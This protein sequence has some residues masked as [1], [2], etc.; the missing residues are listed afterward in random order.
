MKNILLLDTSFSAK[1]IY[2][3]LEKSGNVYVMGNRPDDFLAKISPNYINQNYADIE[4]VLKVLDNFKINFLVPGGNDFSYKI[5]SKINSIIPFYNTD[6]EEVN[7]IINNKEKF[8]KFSINNNLNVPKLVDEDNI[9]NHL[10]VIIKSVDAYSG[11]GMTIIDNENIDL[12]QESIENA[13]SF[14]KSGNYIIEEFVEG[15]LYSHSAFISNGKIIEDFIVKEYCSTNQYVVDISYVDDDFT[16]QMR[17]EIRKDITTIA[18]ELTL[19]DGLIHTQFIANGDNFWIIEITR[20]C[21]GDLYSQLIEFSTGFPYAEYYTKPFLNVKNEIFTQP[22]EINH[23]LRHTISS[24]EENVF[25]YF[26]LNQPL[27]IRKLLPMVLPGDIVKESP[28]G[29]IGL[30]FVKFENKSDLLKSIPK[31]TSKQIYSVN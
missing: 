21:P 16:S 20:R 31:F 7:E 8:R 19:H 4:S 26:E 23:I 6:S 3:Y 17:E 28:F 25:H 22:K 14:S 15:Q 1:T 12:L 5:C 13:K 18:K 2:D 30:L 24:K 10:P 9:A 11:H 27:I 29:R